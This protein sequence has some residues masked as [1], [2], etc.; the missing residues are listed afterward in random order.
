ME[1]KIIIRIARQELTVNFRN[2]WTVL[3]AAVF[4]ALVVSI[5]YFGIMAE[6]FS[7][8]QNFTRTSASILNLVLYIV[9][10]VSLV[11]GTLSFTGDKGSTELLFSQPVSRAEVLLGKLCGLFLSVSLSM[12]GGFAVAGILI[13]SINGEEGLIQYGFFVLLSL[14]LALV[15]LSIAVVVAV[16]NRRKS[17]AFG[18]SLF[19]WFFFVLFYD[20]LALGG[21]ALFKGQDANLFLFLSLFGN[22]VDMVRVATLISLENVSIFGAAGAALL[23]FL[24]GPTSSILLLTISL[25]MWIV[26][27][28]KISQQL[29]SRQDI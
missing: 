22:P 8:M 9:P 5:S 23:R 28:V 24:G 20:L 25:L 13:S 10:L 27:P 15:F 11:M 29:L 16:V 3:F 18:I 19:L 26:V 7:G 14:M 21:S 6:G 1:Y 17:K 4:G 2:K 12:L